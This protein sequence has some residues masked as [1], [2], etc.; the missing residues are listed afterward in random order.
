MARRTKSIKTETEPTI[1]ER[2]L[3]PPKA[4]FFKKLRKIVSCV[5][6]MEREQ[7]KVSIKREDKFPREGEEIK[8]RRVTEL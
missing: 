8:F 1:F 6:W 2:F 3:P 7:E 5:R 4:S